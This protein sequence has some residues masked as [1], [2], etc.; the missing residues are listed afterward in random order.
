MTTEEL[1]KKPDVWFINRNTGRVG[2]TKPVIVNNGPEKNQVT[3]TF[4]IPKNEQKHTF[5]WFFNE[6]EWLEEVRK[7]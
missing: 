2:K 1:M 3:I 6:Q 5:D 7:L 4:E